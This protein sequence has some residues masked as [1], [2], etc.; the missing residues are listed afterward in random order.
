MSLILSF[1]HLSSFVLAV[2]TSSSSYST[3]L[4]LTPSMH[5]FLEHLYKFFKY[6][7]LLKKL[8]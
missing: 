2:F 7:V 8:K 3:T 5:S 1:I 6:V 4:C